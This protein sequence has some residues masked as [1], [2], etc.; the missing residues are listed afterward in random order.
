MIIFQGVSTVTGSIIDLQVMSQEEKIIPAHGLTV[1]PA[2]I[3]PHVHFRTPGWEYKED[4]RTGAKAAIRGGCTMVFDMPNT[5]PPTFTAHLLR[6]KKT[7]IDQQ[8]RD[9]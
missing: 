7:L 5:Q 6:E 9:V 4:W 1:L 3:D 2:V 8:L